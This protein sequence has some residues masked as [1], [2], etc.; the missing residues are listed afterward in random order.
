MSGEADKL[1]CWYAIHTKPKQEDRVDSNLRAWGFETFAPKFKEYRS[2]PYTQ[3]TSCVIKHL[4]PS[5]I[6]AKFDY[7]SLFYK[8]THTRGTHSVVRFGDQPAVLDELIISLIQSRI[9]REGFVKMDDDPK[10][11]DEVIIKD[12]PF[13]GLT[14]VFK[15]EVKEHERVM[16]LLN[17]VSYQAQIV[18]NRHQVKKW[19]D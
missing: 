1:P 14:G 2:N 10:P 5:Y 4:F 3:E 17:A 7:E 11:G 9:D 15:Q 8:V 6:F 19:Q 13:K 18:I 16:I 12:G